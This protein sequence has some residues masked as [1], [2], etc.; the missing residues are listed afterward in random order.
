MNLYGDHGN[1][2]VLQRRAEWRGFE[3]EII[4]HEI[5]DKLPKDIDIIF[6]GGGQDS[7]QLKISEDIKNNGAEI[8][9]MIEGGVPALLVCGVYQL[10]GKT[11]ETSDGK[12]VDSIGV[13]DIET[14]GSSERI[15]GNV[16]VD[17]K[18]F[19]EIVGYE[20]HQGRTRLS[21]SVEPLGKI[22]KGG[23]NN[24]EDGSEGAIYKN[25]I[26]T[27]LHG[28]LLPKNPKLADFLILEALERKGF[29]GEFEKLDDGLE[30]RAREVAK[31]R[32]R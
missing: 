18:K 26:G 14:F 2:L 11:F 6:G 13:F 20:N 21:A 24:G 28:P 7:G 25:A 15:I 22:V 30:D 16:I 5:G 10:F 9:N 17:S 32:P 19:G 3:V 31:N 27:Y 4:E 8:K 12:K 29:K 23:G 1:V